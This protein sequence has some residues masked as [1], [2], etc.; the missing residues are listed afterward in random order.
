MN[1]DDREDSPVSEW[2]SR[3]AGAG[4]ATAEPVDRRWFEEALRAQGF[5]V[6]A[7]ATH[8]K[9]SW[10]DTADVEPL[11][12]TAELHDEDDLAIAE[13]EAV[14]ETEPL[15]AEL[16]AEPEAATEAFTAEPEAAAEAFTAETTPL[17]EPWD[18][19]PI[20][21]PLTS[22]P[23]IGMT[24]ARLVPVPAPAATEQ[25]V[26]STARQAVVPATLPQ[27]VLPVPSAALAARLARPSG[28]TTFTPATPAAP[29]V[30]PL[31][32]VT[33]AA[34]ETLAP[35]WAVAEIVPAAEAPVTSSETSV[36]TDPWALPALQADLA[37]EPPIAVDHATP[38]SA[39]ASEADVAVVVATTAAVTA[40]PQPLE[41]TTPVPEAVDLLAEAAVQPAEA[42]VQP[43]EAAV[44]PAE[45]AVQPAEAAVQPVK[46]TIAEAQSATPFS[47]FITGTAAVASQ[48]TAATVGTTVDG[49][50]SDLWEL[51]GD[52][53]K[54][55]T[56]ASAAP[57]A[58]SSTVTT[59]LL[60]IFVAIVVVALVLG[61]IY[62]F[63]SLL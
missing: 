58:K 18:L 39:A 25:P 56:T 4:T 31:P 23:V 26:V 34:A 55:S 17:A 38:E 51:V 22:W 14:L 32:G 50:D 44:Q 12:A 33:S 36:A 8:D 16:K 40:A 61:F 45:A 48:P 15:T 5:L 11:T 7:P 6:D 19:A 27:D 43:A 47:P 2:S 53:A 28:P 30:A 63:T 10:S 49:G 42:A 37:A 9:P 13:A 3:T 57:A 24:P 54:P 62:L 1:D 52:P 59:A 41:A 29:T 46:A 20:V 35:A 60:T 21:T